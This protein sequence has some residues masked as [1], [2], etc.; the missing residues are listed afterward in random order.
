MDWRFRSS[1]QAVELIEAVTRH[2][3]SFDILCHPVDPALC[4]YAETEPDY[5]AKVRAFYKELGIA[6]AIWASPAEQPPQYVEIDKE[7]EH[8]LHLDLTRIVAYVDEDTWSPYLYGKRNDF[9]FSQQPV[10]YA[11]TSLII[12]TPL[13]ASE[14]KWFRRYERTRPDKYKVVEDRPWP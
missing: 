10:R 4:M 1:R 2:D 9:Q 11:N 5:V 8:V 14:V 6:S 13:A 7:Y 3:A 12:C